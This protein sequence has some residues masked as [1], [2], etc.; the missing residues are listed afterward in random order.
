LKTQNRFLLTDAGTGVV[1]LIP[2]NRGQVPSYSWQ[3][4]G[5]VE[6]PEDRF[7]LTAGNRDRFCSTG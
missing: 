5:Q 2:E 6:N 7:L 1:S 4:Q 3:E